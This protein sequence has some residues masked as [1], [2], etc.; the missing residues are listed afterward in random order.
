MNRKLKK[1]IITLK[2]KGETLAL[3]ES[4]SG[5]YAS[6][7]LTKTP[8]ASEVFKGSVVVYSLE[9]KNKLFG[10]SSSI[11]KKTQ[12]VSKEVVLKLATRVRKKFNTDIGASIVGFAGPSVKIKA[13]VGTTFIAYSSKNKQKVK[14][15]IIKGSRDSVR[16]KASTYLI[17]LIYKELSKK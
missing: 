14:K 1:L 13:Q 11:L 4:C 2:E 8:G 10:I 12:G 7:L 3:A 16:K 6:Y 9:A 15:I 17:D 5:G